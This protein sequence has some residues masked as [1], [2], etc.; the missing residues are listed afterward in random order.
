MATSWQHR[1]R[2]RVGDL[3]PASP[4]PPAGRLRLLGMAAVM[5][6]VVAAQSPIPAAADGNDPVSAAEAI[7]WGRRAGEAAR[8]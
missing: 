5:I 1:V 7:S 3:R 2:D 4:N 8:G 6:G